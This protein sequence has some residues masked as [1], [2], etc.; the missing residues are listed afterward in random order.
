MPINPLKLSHRSQGREGGARHRLLVKTTR[1][2]H[3][4][5]TAAWRGLLVRIWSL[6][7]SIQSTL[8]FRQFGLGMGKDL[9]NCKATKIKLPKSSF[10]EMSGKSRN[11]RYMG[12]TNSKKEKD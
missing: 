4:G 3:K 6:L 12:K 2:A 9:C 7:E 11:S 5:R 1:S 8:P 10:I